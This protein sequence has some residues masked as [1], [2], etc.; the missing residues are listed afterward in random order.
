MAVIPAGMAGGRKREFSWVSDR[1]SGAVKRSGTHI[2]FH[3][4]DDFYEERK[5]NMCTIKGRLR[6]FVGLAVPVLLVTLCMPVFGVGQ[7]GKTQSTQGPATLTKVEKAVRHE[8]IMLPNYTIFDN[9]E[10]RVENNNEVVL[11]GQVVWEYLKDEAERAVEHVN[12]ITKVVNNIEVLPLTPYDNTIRRRE[13]FAIYGSIGFE[14]YAIQAVP[15][16]HIIVNNG[17][18][19]LVGV[20]ADQFDKRRAEIAANEVPQVFSVTDNLRVEH[21]S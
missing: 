11:S 16:I 3:S 8:L 9:L 13:F 10:F 12:G 1:I 17:H 14:K 6:N 15:P 18:V 20:V 19:T 5:A 21:T 7:S 4:R 2:A